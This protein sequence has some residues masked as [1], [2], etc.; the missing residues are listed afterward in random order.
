MNTNFLN[1]KSPK[2]LLT[3]LVLFS[4]FP[5]AR[6]DEKQS[7]SARW[8][9]DIAAYEAADKK[10]PPPTG[11]ILFAGASGIRMWK[12]LPQDFPD[13]TII[14]RGIWRLADG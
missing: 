8:E 11:A 5:F 3:L 14:N 6:A 7:P 9:K 13:H 10:S 1:S 12:T 4:F 2:A